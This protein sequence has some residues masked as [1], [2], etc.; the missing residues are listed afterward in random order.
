[1][2]GRVK[3]ASSTLLMGQGTSQQDAGPSKASPGDQSQGFRVSHLPTPE[4]MPV[5]DRL[6]P[7]KVFGKLIFQR[8][9]LQ[10]C[11]DAFS[12][13]KVCKNEE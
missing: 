3:T 6:Q 10:N 8:H 5:K 9:V 2:F 1:M 12:Q 4:W 13:L 11:T 7:T